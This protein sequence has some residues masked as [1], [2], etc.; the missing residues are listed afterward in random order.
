MAIP[1]VIEVN[2][3]NV[4]LKCAVSV[5]VRVYIIRT[6]HHAKTISTPTKY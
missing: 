4:M 6:Q 5:S 1:W 2:Q 3:L